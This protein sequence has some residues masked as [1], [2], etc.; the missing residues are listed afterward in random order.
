MAWYTIPRRG[1]PDL[2]VEYEGAPPC[3]WCG[4]PVTEP[5]MDGPLVCGWCDMGVTRCEDG[6]VRKWDQREHAERRE[7]FQHAIERIAAG[8]VNHADRSQ[9]LPGT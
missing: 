3:L 6:S 5:S 4:T 9:D 1:L 2:E 8:R 7:H